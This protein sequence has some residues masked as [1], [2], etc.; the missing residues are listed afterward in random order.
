MNFF[1]Q[2]KKH[3]LGWIAISISILIICLWAYWGINENFHEGWYYRSL[4]KNLGLLFIQYLS[5]MLITMVLTLIAIRWHKPGGVIFILIGIAFSL[6]IF[7]TIPEITF[8]IVLSWIPVTLLLVAVGLLYWFGHLRKKR[9][10]FTLAIGIPVVLVIIFSVE[11]LIRISNRVNEVSGEPYV[12][13]KNDKH[14]VWAPEGPGWSKKG[15]LSRN[16]T[17]K[18]CARLQEDGKTL[19][20]TA[21]NIWRLPNVK[22]AV[23]SMTRHTENC[24][25]MWDEEK[26]KAV[27]EVKPDKEPPLWDPYSRVIYYWT[28]TEI[29]QEKAY[30]I[31]YSGEVWRKSKDSK[32]GSLGFRAVKEVNN[33]R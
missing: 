4:S 2:I 6:V 10:A 28:S 8:G 30:I 31:I 32:M 11:P 23:K 5:P 17:R 16:E 7:I 12:I 25:G 3:H 29:N 33:K 27:Y 9:I 13:S 22:E 15:G 14:L 26:E 1:K 18:I 19:A 21:L 24:N 20:D